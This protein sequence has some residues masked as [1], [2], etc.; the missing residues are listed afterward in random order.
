MPVV[1]VFVF[2][3]VDMIDNRDSISGRKTSKG[4]INCE[5]KRIHPPWVLWIFNYHLS[6]KQEAEI[7]EVEEHSL[8]SKMSGFVRF[9]FK[10][11]LS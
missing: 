10:E 3:L 4:N 9:N 8:W 6:N 1:M 7:K 2:D 5:Y 11:F